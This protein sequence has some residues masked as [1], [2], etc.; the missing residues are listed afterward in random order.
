MLCEDQREEEEDGRRQERC[1]DAGRG[2]K[3][4]E[5]YR[6]TGKEEKRSEKKK[7]VSFLTATPRKGTPQETGSLLETGRLQKPKHMIENSTVP[8]KIETGRGE[9]SG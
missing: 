9:P 7:S 6:E 3:G 5:R 1:R 2:R 4:R 8:G